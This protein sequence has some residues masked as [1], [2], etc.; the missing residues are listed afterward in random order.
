MALIEK[1]IE[2]EK[3][4]NDIRLKVDCDKIKDNFK[5]VSMS[6]DVNV[7]NGYSTNL[8]TGG[9]SVKVSGLDA[10]VK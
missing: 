4:G 3:E 8:N 2:T 1:A 9:G 7:P 6:F 5:S 10:I